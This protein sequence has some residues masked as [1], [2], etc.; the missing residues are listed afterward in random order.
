MK[1]V[2]K[3]VGNK[4]GKKGVRGSK[5]RERIFNNDTVLWR[6]HIREADNGNVF[7]PVYYQE[8]GYVIDYIMGSACISKKA[9]DKI[10]DGR[11]FVSYMKNGKAF[12]EGTNGSVQLFCITMKE[13]VKWLPKEIVHLYAPNLPV[14][15]GDISFI[16]GQSFDV[17]EE[18]IALNL[19][20][21][22]D[23][24]NLECVV[25]LLAFDV[26]QRIQ[27]NWRE[28]IPCYENVTTVSRCEL[29]DE[30]SELREN[31]EIEAGRIERKTSSLV[32]RF[33]GYSSLARGELMDGEYGGKMKS[34]SEIDFGVSHEFKTG[35]FWFQLT[36]IRS[37]KNTKVSGIYHGEKSFECE[38]Y[39]KTGVVKIG[40]YLTLQ[41]AIYNRCIAEEKYFGTASW[42]TVYHKGELEK[43]KLIVEDMMKRRDE[44]LCKECMGM[45][46]RIPRVVRG[47]TY[48]LKSEEEYQSYMEGLEK[49]LVSDL[50]ILSCPCGHICVAVYELFEIGLRGGNVANALFY[51]EEKKKEEEEDKELMDVEEGGEEKVDP[52]LFKDDIDTFSDWFEYCS[53][54][55]DGAP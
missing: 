10:L 33:C 4:E 17:R 34:G 15:Q 22:R 35:G 41:D 5:Q 6:K 8:R 25:C 2:Y 29:E 47:G 11:V 53:Q 14:N 43:T 36:W 54:F 21:P 49:T 50:D 20:F 27:T 12:Y 38:I 37:R 55:Y 51:R 18:N 45:I 42:V 28:D 30:S 7:I 31:L 46:Q 39:T 3:V 1:S 13:G 16:N 24:F 44:F 48:D 52:N 9:C 23:G 32:E 19:L 40:T 26:G